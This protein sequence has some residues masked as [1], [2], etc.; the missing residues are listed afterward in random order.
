MSLEL[1]LRPNCRLPPLRTLGFVPVHH[2]AVA[3]GC[4]NTMLPRGRRATPFSRSSPLISVAAER[5]DRSCKKPGISRLCFLSVGWPLYCRCFLLHRLYLAPFIKISL[6]RF[7]RRIEISR[8]LHL[9]TGRTLSG[10]RADLRDGPCLARQET[11]LPG[12]SCPPCPQTV[13]A[14]S[15]HPDQCP[16]L[17]P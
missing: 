15:G 13:R 11:V 4:W 10:Q 7:L 12:T 1:N 16:K 8:H 3:P 5:L 17:R 14:S 6:Y 9:R 2:L